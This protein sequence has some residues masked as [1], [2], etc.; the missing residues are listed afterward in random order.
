MDVPIIPDEKRI[1][2]ALVL[3]RERARGDA[4]QDARAKRGATLRLR[5]GQVYRAPTTKDWPRYCLWTAFARRVGAPVVL[6]RRPFTETL[7]PAARLP[8][9][10]TFSHSI[11]ETRL[12]LMEVI[13]GVAPVKSGDKPVSIKVPSP[14]I[15]PI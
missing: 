11:S 4:Q 3:G 6:N 13:G 9:P 12:T 7:L 5:S 10:E 15:V 1:L 8:R 2:A 14:L